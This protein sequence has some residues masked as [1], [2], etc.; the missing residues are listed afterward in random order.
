LKKVNVR[1]C[2]LFNLNEFVFVHILP[3]ASFN[4]FEIKKKAAVAATDGLQT[5]FG[6]NSDDSCLLI[7]PVST[8]PAI[9]AS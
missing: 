3:L 4:S 5:G 2:L 8:S 1:L 6:G 7:K 9:N